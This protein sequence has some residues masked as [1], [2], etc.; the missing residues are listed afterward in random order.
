MMMNNYHQNSYVYISTLECMHFAALLAPGT[1]AESRLMTVPT[2]RLW[3]TSGGCMDGTSGQDLPVQPSKVL[4]CNGELPFL[5]WMRDENSIMMMNMMGSSLKQLF[6][7]PLLQ[8]LRQ[9]TQSNY[10]NIRME[11]ERKQ[12]F[13]HTNNP[14]LFVSKCESPL[15]VIEGMSD[16][17]P[18]TTTNK[19]REGEPLY[20]PP[21]TWWS[22]EV[23]RGNKQQAR[24]T[25]W[26]IQKYNIKTP[27]KLK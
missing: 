17:H 24:T 5:M 18:P 11:V 16:F 1:A 27:C 3:T 21:L 10:S 2:G 15:P 14:T 8:Q 9:K 23:S 22:Q 19:G 4:H 26:L 6:K 12:I 7:P 20:P 13:S 25:R